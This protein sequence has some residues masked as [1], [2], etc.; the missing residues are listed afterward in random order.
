MH[1]NVNKSKLEITFQNLDRRF[2]QIELNIVLI[3]LILSVLVEGFSR[4]L[5]IPCPLSFACQ[6]WDVLLNLP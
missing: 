5:S 6:P 4:V 2:V 3:L 1:A